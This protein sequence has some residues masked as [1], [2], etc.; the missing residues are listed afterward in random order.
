MSGDLNVQAEI[1][2]EEKSG[3]LILKI[4]E[5]LTKSKF[6]KIALIVLFAVLFAY[7]ISNVK[8][9]GRSWDELE[10]ITIVHSNWIEYAIRLFPDGSS[11]K[12]NALSAGITPISIKFERDHGAAP[13]YFF[14]PFYKMYEEDRAGMAYAWHT[15]TF[16]V[17]FLGVIASW[18]L[19]KEL[20]GSAVIATAGMLFYYFTPRFFAEGHYNDKDMVFMG[21]VMA[22]ALFSIRAAKKLSLGKK[23][24]WADILL[25]SLLSGFMMNVKIIG[26]AIWGL[27]GLFTIIY[28]ATRG[29]NV[30]IGAWI[31]IVLTVLISFVMYIVLTPAS[32]AGILDFFK[33]LIDNALHY[34]GWY[35][36]V[37]FRGTLFN[38]AEIGIP[39]T[40]IP[41]WMLITIPEYITILF[42]LS[43]VWFFVT[44]I[45][46]KGKNLIKDDE[47][48]YF[49][50]LFLGFAI[51]FSFVVAKSHTEV[52]YN[53]WR[54]MYFLYAFMLPG[55]L[56]FPCKLFK[57]VKDRPERR[58]NRNVSIVY[59]VI[60]VL[61]LITAG[62]MIA[63]RSFEYVYYNLT[64][65]AVL[66]VKGYEGDYWMVSV[67]PAL[68]E[69]AEEYYDGE[70]P[71]K[72]ACVLFEEHGA[73]ASML[74]A[75]KIKFTH[76]D[77]AD[78]LIYNPSGS[79]DWP[80]LEDHDKVF[81]LNRFGVELTGIYAK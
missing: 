53:S 52:L 25:F 55:S 17:Y 48:F 21:L 74:D 4:E 20:Y 75:D 36:F 38:P 42:S 9:Y 79:Y 26:V 31:K 35:G 78:Y 80:E 22:C 7:G 6:S 65:R 37:R 34:S 39:Y 77:E 14:L 66:D 3:S 73:E 69:F 70:H 49:L 56:Y 72:V 19:L 60:T 46:Q 10:A 1:R 63:N 32:W 62:E 2:E 27:M 44:T 16:C 71:L 24:V 67:V 5:V 33:F 13:F 8:E 41:T 18:F 45:R 51:P 47:D 30:K 40:Y 11:V 12:E 29:K 61:F 23:G 50:M 68:R 59:G 43:V 58:K 64:A 15:Y 76:P 28:V 54:H 81:S 57:S